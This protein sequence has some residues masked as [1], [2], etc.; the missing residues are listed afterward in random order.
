[1]VDYM[2]EG[3]PSA[4]LFDVLFTELSSKRLDEEINMEDSDFAAISSVYGNLSHAA[5]FSKISSVYKTKPLPES[6]EYN[7]EIKVDDSKAKIKIP[8]LNDNQMPYQLLNDCAAA[9]HLVNH[10]EDGD[11]ISRR[12]NI[13]LKY[14][15]KYYPGLALRALMF[16]LQPTEMVLEDDDLHLIRDGKLLVKIPLD[17]EGRF[18]RFSGCIAFLSAF[19][20]PSGLLRL[21]FTRFPF[22]IAL[23]TEL[24]D[25]FMPFC[26]NAINI[27]FAP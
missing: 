13:L 12:C 5:I 22:R 16:E 6:A 11:G 10:I 24:K 3:N 15:G 27:R 26:C 7:F 4:V 25:V 20:R 1:M 18:R 8:E 9:V 2:M 14:Q 19:V 23:L 21:R 17:R